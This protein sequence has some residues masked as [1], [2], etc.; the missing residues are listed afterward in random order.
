M[1]APLV[2][3]PA[4]RFTAPGAEPRPPLV[5]SRH[6]RATIGSVHNADAE[7]ARRHLAEAIAALYP[8]LPACTT[9]PDAW[10][11]TAR[12]EHAA[13]TLAD[14]VAACERCPL[15]LPCLDAGHFETWGIWGGIDRDGPRR[16]HRERY[17]AQRDG[18]A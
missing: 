1:T 12:G 13:A 16:D 15:R 9:N 8:V 10:F 6:D 18:A 5:Y 17:D 7:P 4:G 14:C 3:D 2:R 11:A